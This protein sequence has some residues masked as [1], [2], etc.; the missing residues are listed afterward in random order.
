MYGT[1]SRRWPAWLV[2]AV[3]VIEEQRILEHNA[4]VKAQIAEAR[5]RRP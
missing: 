4:G 1:D 2:D 5:N 3:T